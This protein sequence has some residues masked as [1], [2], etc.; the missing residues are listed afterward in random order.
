MPRLRLTAAEREQRAFRD[1]VRGLIL[2]HD[3]TNTILGD[4]IGISGAEIGRKL[5]GKN[6]FTLDQAIAICEHFGESYKIG[7]WLDDR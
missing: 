5:S 6:K 4:A 3:E 2:D 7:R 1:W